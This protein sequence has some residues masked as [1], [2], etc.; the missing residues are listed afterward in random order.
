MRDIRLETGI[1]VILKTVRLMGLEFI[2][3]NLEKY[4]MGTGK[5][6]INTGMVCGKEKMDSYR[7][8]ETDR[9]STRLN[10]S[11]ITRSRMPSSA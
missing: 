1:E 11:H 5:M 7:D 2:N 3:G 4:M 9:K 10:S 6:G 8:W